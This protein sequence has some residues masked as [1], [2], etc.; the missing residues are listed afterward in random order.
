MQGTP[1]R[2]PLPRDL[3]ERLALET[4]LFHVDEGGTPL[5]RGL[6]LEPMVALSDRLRPGMR[7]LETGAGGSTVIFAAAGARHTAVTPNSE[8]IDR[9]VA[10]CRREGISTESVDFLVGSSD[11]VLV[12]WW[13][14]LD[15]LL[16]DGA[17]RF[18]FPVLDWHYLAPHLR[19][20]GHLFLDDVPIPAV[21]L[22]YDFLRGEPDWSLVAIHGDKLAEFQKTAQTLKDPVKDWELQNF[23]QAW[24]Y[25]HVPLSR[26]WRTWRDRA[27]LRTRLRRLGRG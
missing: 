18:P 7:T 8:E 24:R 14:T 21:H 10:F 20:G 6:T 19:V 3:L 16:I 13:T 26:R 25:D 5:A 23:N 2:L 15:L 9:I 27:M 12:D 4:G 17:H 1:T 11:L 22:V